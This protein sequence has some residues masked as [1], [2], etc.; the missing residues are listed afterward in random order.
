MLLPFFGICL[1]YSLG[2][3][4]FSFLIISIFFPGKTISLEE[5][6]NYITKIISIL[7][8][9]ITFY[10][11]FSPPVEKTNFILLK[12]YLSKYNISFLLYIIAILQYFSF[13]IIMDTV[14]RKLYNSCSDNIP[15]SQNTNVQINKK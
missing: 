12:E 15:T 7:L 13:K 4:I 8:F 10:F 2:N 5:K 9:W 6:Q 3:F 11:V 14:L 1:L